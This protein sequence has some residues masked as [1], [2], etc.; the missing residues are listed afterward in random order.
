[1]L[2]AEPRGVPV[3]NSCGRSVADLASGGWKTTHEAASKAR[4]QIFSYF[5]SIHS[6]NFNTNLRWRCSAVQMGRFTNHQLISSVN[7]KKKT[8]QWFWWYLEL[9][10]SVSSRN[11]RHLWFASPTSFQWKKTI[12]QLGSS[13]LETWGPTLPPAVWLVVEPPP[14]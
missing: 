8:I 14:F 11:F 10:S 9:F 12:G 13:Q 6:A 1:M 5:V 3:W 2:V 7:H 4:V